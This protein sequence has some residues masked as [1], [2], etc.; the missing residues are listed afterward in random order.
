MDLAFPKYHYLLRNFWENRVNE[1]AKRLDEIEGYRK[2]I[3]AGILVKHNELRKTYKM[4]INSETEK[5][6]FQLIK[7][8]YDFLKQAVEL[9]NTYNTISYEEYNFD[10]LQQELGIQTKVRDF[11]AFEAL[12]PAVFDEGAAISYREISNALF[13]GII[14][15]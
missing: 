2:N 4:D 8:K 12:S 7:E 9:R 5:L 14:P 10:K 3:L 11:N 6:K 15:E 13:F 1:T